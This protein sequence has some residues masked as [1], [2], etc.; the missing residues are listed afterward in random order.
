[1][2]QIG[3]LLESRGRPEYVDFI[4]VILALGELWFPTAV[5]FCRCQF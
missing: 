3:R 1:M 5:Y 2:G 4:Q